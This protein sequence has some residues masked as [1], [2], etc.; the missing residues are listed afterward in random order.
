MNLPINIPP[1]VS[2]RFYI[3]VGVLA[4]KKSFNSLLNDID[5]FEKLTPILIEHYETKDSID[6]FG[7]KVEKINVWERHVNSASYE[8]NYQISFQTGR[9]RY[10]KAILRWYPYLGF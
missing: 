7:K 9:G 5:N 8:N 3:K 10:F 1:G 2:V 4:N 6:I